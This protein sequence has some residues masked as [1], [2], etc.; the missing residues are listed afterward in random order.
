MKKTNVKASPGIG[1]N[2]KLGNVQ[3]QVPK[4]NL[5]KNPAYPNQGTPK[6]RPMPFEPLPTTLPGKGSDF[7]VKT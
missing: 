3:P 5:I 6:Q 4:N 2:T 1:G 7:R